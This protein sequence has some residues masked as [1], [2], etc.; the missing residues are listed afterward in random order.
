MKT[1]IFEDV[2]NNVIQK[3][4]S[5]SVCNFDDILQLAHEMQK[6]EL[7]THIII[8]GQNGMGK[9]YLLLYLMFLFYKKHSIKKIS[10]SELNKIIIENLMLAKHTTNDLV[11]YMLQKEKTMCGVDEYNQ[12]LY[13]KQHAESL[14]SHLITQLEL[15]RSKQIIFIGCIRDPR[16]LSYNYRNGKMSIVIW[17]LDRYQEGGGYA[18]VFI[19]NPSV[20]AEDRFGFSLLPEYLT[21]FDVLKYSM[22]KL[23]SFVGFVKI[24]N[25][26]NILPQSLVDLYKSE[27]RI[28]M[29]YAHINKNIELL[30]RGKIL[31]DELVYNIQMVKNIIPDI[32]QYVSI[33]ISSTPN[34][35]KLTEYQE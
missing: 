18:A 28:A 13:Y 9:S 19:A 23:P 35:K 3:F 25:L 16:K 30:K 29:A 5:D 14:Q 10:Q 15:A 11:L 20:E 27:K 33:R 21:D 22:E 4:I 12:Y 26:T 8:A 7:D 6:N 31:K 1:R 24:P 2:Y 17:I 34:Y 32:E